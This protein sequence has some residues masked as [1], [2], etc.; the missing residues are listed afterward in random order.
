MKREVMGINYGCLSDEFF[1]FVGCSD[2]VFWNQGFVDE[3]FFDLVLISF[4]DVEIL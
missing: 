4:S 3:D 1:V 2:Y